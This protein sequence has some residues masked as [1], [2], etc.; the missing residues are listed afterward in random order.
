MGKNERELNFV[1][2]NRRK[3]SKVDAVTP[4]QWATIIHGKK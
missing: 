1:S 4:R 2:G 3:R